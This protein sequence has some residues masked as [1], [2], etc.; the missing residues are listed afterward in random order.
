M[1]NDTLIKGDGKHMD[2]NSTGVE[3]NRKEVEPVRILGIVGS[4]RKS[5]NTEIMVERALE[6]AREV[7]RVTTETFL[8]HGRTFEGCKASCI[9]YCQKHGECVIEDDLAAFMEAWLRADGILFGVPVYHMGPPAQ[10]KAAIDRM[11]NVLFSYLRG[12]IPRFNK[13]CAAIVQ[14]SSRWGGQEI[15][16]QFLLEHFVTMYGLPIV[17]DKPGPYLGA[18]GYAKTWE[19]DSIIE[20][21]FGLQASRNLGRR[22]A[23]T[24]RIVKAG[25]NLLADELPDVYSMEKLMAA[26]EREPRPAGLAWQKAST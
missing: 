20:D 24:A 11:G 16:A 13:V 22:V 6:G 1:G 21:E 8:F 23:E 12:R 4:P 14:G 9:R 26:A 25:M 17:G 10:V 18:I 3:E 5:G 15:T 7:S 19:P 2:S